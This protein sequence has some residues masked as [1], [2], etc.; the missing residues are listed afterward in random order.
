MNSPIDDASNHRIWTICLITLTALAST[1]TVYW[2]RPVLVPL[3]VAVFVV[4]GVSPILVTLERRLGVNRLIAAVLTFLAGVVLMGL[5]GFTIWASLVDLGENSDAYGR[6]VR[7]LVAEIEQRFPIELTPPDRNAD[8]ENEDAENEDA[9][10]SSN[11]DAADSNRERDPN[12]GPVELTNAGESDAGATIKGSEPQPANNNATEVNGITNNQ[13]VEANAGQDEATD[14]GLGGMDDTGSTGA[15]QYPS[16]PDSFSSDRLADE[17]T[18]GQ[19][20]SEFIDSIIRQGI[21]VVSQSLISMVSTSA[22]VLIYVFFLL[23]G[24]PTGHHS[25][26]FRE[27]D[28]QIRSYLA[29]KTIISIFTGGAFGLALQLFGVPMSFTF[30]VMAFLL[31]FV[32]NVGPLVAS[33]LPIPLIVLDPSGSL[34]WMVTTITV[35]CTIQL[36]SGN[37]IEPKIM[38]DSSDLHPVT[39]LLALMFW[40]MM[41]GI[42]GMFLATPITAAMKIVLERIDQTRPIAGWMA[43]RWTIDE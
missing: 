13:D 41:W 18:T 10:G 8:A 11:S 27:V 36:V 37:F 4:S 1:Y 5:F 9:D 19:Y 12:D 3:V 6:R 24:T 17:P 31:N 21:S 39:I 20:N 2:L 25:E 40:G 30:G 14:R 32:P 22:V 16:R 28:L 29:L 38:G 7:E 42:I 33:L 15:E 35:I 26:T 34:L 23:I 43:G